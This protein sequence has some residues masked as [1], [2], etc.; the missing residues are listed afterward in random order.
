MKWAYPCLPLIDSD[1][2]APY[3]CEEIEVALTAC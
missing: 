1:G 3:S 2:P